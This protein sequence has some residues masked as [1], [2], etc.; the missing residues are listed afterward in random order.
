VRSAPNDA[1]R[2]VTREDVEAT[3]GY[4]LGAGRLAPNPGRLS[5]GN[6]TYLDEPA[7]RGLEVAA[8]LGEST[9]E[10]DTRAHW[11]NLRTTAS[12]RGS[13]P[14]Q[15]LGDEAYFVPDL[16]LLQVLRGDLV[17]GLQLADPALI[18]DA[19][20]AR[21]MALARAALGRL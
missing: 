21:L 1:C 19:T 18:P 20:R 3:L 8:I 4:S 13:Q 16:R 2:L 9:Q 11:T 10:K 6:C 15:G 17:L 5:S 12:L 7:R 14:V